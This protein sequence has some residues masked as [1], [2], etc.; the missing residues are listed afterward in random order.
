MTEELRG[1][2]TDI[3]S[4]LSPIALSLKR[5]I[6]SG[7]NMDI[8]DLDVLGHE[9]VVI[10]ERFSAPLTEFSHSILTITLMNAGLSISRRVEELRIR[11]MNEDDL[12]FLNDV[13]SLVKLIANTIESGEYYQELVRIYQKKLSEGH[14]IRK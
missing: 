6:D 13:Y 12:A 14:R 2:L 3:Y 8:K 10:S 1:I 7:L 4:L 5:C 9:L 11:G